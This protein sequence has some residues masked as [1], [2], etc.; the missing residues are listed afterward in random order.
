MIS[1]AGNQKG[2]TRRF[3]PNV[4]SNSV[5]SKKEILFFFLSVSLSFLAILANL[6]T[7]FNKFKKYVA[8][9]K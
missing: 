8:N 2:N 6:F 1:E 3:G 7:D 9:L 5:E 4:E